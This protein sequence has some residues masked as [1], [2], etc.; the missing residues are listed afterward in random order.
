MNDCE[1][2]E[3]QDKLQVENKERKL[4]TLTESGF[5]LKKFKQRKKK[6]II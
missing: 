2:K 5:E 6:H 1:K 3:E 4:Q